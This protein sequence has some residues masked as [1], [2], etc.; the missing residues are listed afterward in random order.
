[1]LGQGQAE[2]AATQARG[3]GLPASSVRRPGPSSG[4]AA[5]AGQPPAA[6]AVPTP[7]GRGRSSG[8]FPGPGYGASRT[9]VGRGAGQCGPAALAWQQRRAS[10]GQPA[11]QQWQDGARPARRRRRPTRPRDPRPLRA[12]ASDAGAG[13]Q[14]S[15]GTGPQQSFGTG[16]Q[17]SYG[18]A[19]SGPLRHGARSWAGAQAGTQPAQQ[20]GTFGAPSHRRG[21][22]PARLRRP[23]GI[24][25]VARLPGA[26]GAARHGTLPR[27]PV[28]GAA[29]H[30]DRNAAGGYGTDGG[31]PANGYGASANGHHANGYQ[32]SGTQ[33]DLSHPE[34]LSGRGARPRIRHPPAPTPLT[35]NGYASGAAQGECPRSPGGAA[36]SGN[37]SAAPTGLPMYGQAGPVGGFGRS[38][39]PAARP[40]G[41]RLRPGI[42]AAR[43]PGR[44]HPNAD[45]RAGQRYGLARRGQRNSGARASLPVAGYGPAPGGGSPSG[46]GT[47]LSGPAGLARTGTAA[48]PRAERQ[49][50]ASRAK[51]ATAAV[52]QRLPATP[53]T[54]TPAASQPGTGN[55]NWPLLRQRERLPSM[56]ESVPA[57]GYPRDGYPSGRQRGAP[58]PGYPPVTWLRSAGQHGPATPGYWKPGAAASAEI[59]RKQGNRSPV[60]PVKLHWPVRLGS[61]G[62]HLISRL[63][64]LPFG[65]SRDVPL[66]EEATCRTGP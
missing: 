59:G 53:R 47:G 66:A 21:P 45:Y 37:G 35:P 11:A 4:G 28:A 41:I 26:G 56:N 1:M 43:R 25:A 64:G 57:D 46:S 9:A 40:N 62:P 18:G 52:R 10:T 7:A 34:R 42:P 55:V 15:Y 51:P 30:D 54:A 16:A 14:Q 50:S 38:A 20:G 3:A 23:G 39:A 60:Q 6:T 24:P 58:V 29:G 17:Q 19:H 2:Q 44:V 13:A 5:T 61:P 22:V 63:R 33:Q 8:L 27:A 49:G 48:Q 36:T 31:Y 32:A 12:G 65:W